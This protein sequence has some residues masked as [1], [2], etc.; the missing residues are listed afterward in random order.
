MANVKSKEAIV[1]SVQKN[2]GHFAKGQVGLHNDLLSLARHICETGDHTVALTVINIV[3]DDDHAHREA[4]HMVRWLDKYAGVT[5]TETEGED[6]QEIVKTSWKGA[7]F[8]KDNFK[9]G[10]ENPYYK[11]IKKSNPFRFN[12]VEYLETGIVKSNTAMQ[13]KAK[14]P[15][16][17]VNVDGLAE[18][19]ALVAQLK[20]AS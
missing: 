14:D 5:F 10:T 15:A 16:A 11:G 12:L 2:C 3:Q 4:S 20:A 8:I 17:D 13:K 19:K 6:G 7:K 1:A 9:A 18:A